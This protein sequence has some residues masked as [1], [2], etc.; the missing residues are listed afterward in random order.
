M[1]QSLKFILT[2]AWNPSGF[3]VVFAFP[4]G[5]KFDTAYHI[6]TTEILERIK[7]WWKGQRAGNTRKMIVHADNARLHTAKLSM[8]F[9]NANRMTRAPDLCYSPDLAP[10]DFFLFGDV[11]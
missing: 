7:N 2:V 3:H 6:Y 9:M 8:D 4:N 1:M 5:L 11:K 10:S